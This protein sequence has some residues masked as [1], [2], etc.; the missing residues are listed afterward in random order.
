[1]QHKQHCYFVRYHNKASIFPTFA[2]PFNQSTVYNYHHYLFHYNHGLSLWITDY[3]RSTCYIE[4][5]HTWTGGPRTISCLLWSTDGKYQIAAQLVQMDEHTYERSVRTRVLYFRTTQTC[6]ATYPRT[7][8]L[9]SSTGFLHCEV[10]PTFRSK[11]MPP[12]SGWLNCFTCILTWY[13]GNQPA[14]NLIKVGGMQT[15]HVSFPCSIYPYLY[16]KHTARLCNNSQDC[17]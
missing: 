9:W 11:V 1:M 2:L 13:R 3:N 10:V 7:F 17:A 4:P 8:K 16:T 15:A 6:A 14:I 5:N 12:S